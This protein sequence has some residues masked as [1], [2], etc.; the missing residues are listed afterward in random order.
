VQRW[1]A[2][3]NLAE[4]SAWAARAMDSLGTWDPLRKR[5]MVLLVRVSLAQQHAAQAIE[6]LEGWSHYLDQSG[7]S[8][9]AIQFLALQ[10][11]ALHQAGKSEQAAA[12]AVRLLRRTEPEGYLRV[13]LDE[14]D[15]M[16]EALLALLT[17]DFQR[18]PQAPSITAYVS[19]LL[20]VFEDE[21]RA[22]GTSPEAAIALEPASSQVP[23]SSAATSALVASLTRREQEVLHLLAAGA[24]NRE[25]AE[26]LVIELPTVKKHVSNL[27]GKLGVSS[28]MQAI[29]RARTLSLL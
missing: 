12:A 29:V 15:P 22:A 4:V 27:L 26:A 14:G 2:Q 3:G 17:A 6:M 18:Q 10:V 28:R 20:A 21:E 24:S 19:K 8:E 1:L 13:Y 25:I 23:Q 5:E 7:D 11:V 16:R 9:T